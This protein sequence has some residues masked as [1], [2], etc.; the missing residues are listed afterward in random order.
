MLWWIT[1]AFNS[2]RLETGAIFLWLFLFGISYALEPCTPK[3]ITVDEIE[4]NYVYDEVVDTRRAVWDQTPRL[5]I[6]LSQ[7]LF[8]RWNP[9]KS[10]FDT[11]A[12]RLLKV[13]NL[14]ERER[15]VWKIV[16]VDKRTNKLLLVESYSLRLT[17]SSY[18][19]EIADRA[20]L[21]KEERLGLR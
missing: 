14:P 1:T 15:G 4:I 3:W 7:V 21:P 8:K 18:D 19:R 9:A 6:R 16:F 11:H 2:K 10:R 13:V 17:H 12:W 20:I 5:K